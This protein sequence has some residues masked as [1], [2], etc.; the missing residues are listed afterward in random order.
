MQNQI[1]NLMQR[2]TPEANYILPTTTREIPL[3]VSELYQPEL[4]GFLVND[5]STVRYL[6]WSAFWRM[7]CGILLLPIFILFIFC[8]LV[9][10][11]I[12]GSSFF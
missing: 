8:V 2:R 11:G 1:Y 3:K 12:I 9:F 6:N 5:P 10:F 7:C 4:Y